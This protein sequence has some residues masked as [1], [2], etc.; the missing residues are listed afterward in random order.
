[1][2]SEYTEL[3]VVLAMLPPNY[4][5][6]PDT[7]TYLLTST[8]TDY[9][10]PLNRGMLNK[11]LKTWQGSKLEGIHDTRFRLIRDSMAYHI[12]MVAQ[13]PGFLY[14]ATMNRLPQ[15]V[16]AE[17]SRDTHGLIVAQRDLVQNGVTDDVKEAV[18]A[19]SKV[20]LKHLLRHANVIVTT[21]S[22]A[23]SDGFNVHRQ[24]TAVAC[25]VAGRVDDA[26][27][28]GFSSRYLLA[29]ARFLSGSWQQLPP[30]M[31][32]AIRK[33]RIYLDSIH[34]SLATMISR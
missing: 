12:L 2:H 5:Y 31:K 24:A 32:S 19:A 22:M 21:L 3:S 10:G 15:S 28:T 20:A 29:S 34:E 16:L 9:M 27:V 8:D 1:M 7:D 33:Y 18:N 30:S 17:M 11:R 25:E 6:S 23:T 4:S 26:D 13:V 14:S